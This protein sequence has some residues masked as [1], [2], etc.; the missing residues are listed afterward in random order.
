MK[1]V[2]P[3]AAPGAAPV[4]GEEGAVVLEGEG[5][6]DDDDDDDDMIILDGPPANKRSR[7]G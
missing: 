2:V 1:L 7:L 5:E 4:D 6:D 3:A